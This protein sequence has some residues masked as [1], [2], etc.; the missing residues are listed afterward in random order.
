MAKVVRR[1]MPNLPE[2][3]PDE[4]ANARLA[5][6]IMGAARPGFERASDHI[7]DHLP[8]QRPELVRG[9]LRCGHKLMLAAQSKAGKT[10]AMIALAL[11]VANGYER[12]EGDGWDDG[13]GATWLGRPCR[14]GEVC[15][16][17]GE[18]DVAS[19]WH[20]IDLVARAM[21]PD[22]TTSERRSR[23]ERLMVRSLRGDRDIDVSGVLSILDEGYGDDARPALVIIDPIYKLMQ[24]EENSN[25]ETRPFLKGL[26]AIA[27]WGPSVATT[28]HHAKGKAGERQVIDRAAGAG[29]FGRDPDAFVDLTALDI[30]EGTEAWGRLERALPRLDGEGASEWQARLAQSRIYRANYVLREFPDRW[31]HELLFDFPLLVPID[32]FAD[33]PEEGSQQAATLAATEA[34]RS[35][36]DEAWALHDSLLTDAIDRLGAAGVGHPTREAAYAAYAKRCAEEGVEPKPRATMTDATKPSGTGLSWV[37]D[38]SVRGLVRR[39]AKPQVDGGE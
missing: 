18:M 16:F 22:D 37:Y 9:V 32:G 10:W 33:V 19:L 6:G 38:Q 39:S 28:H 34:R 29:A 8:P 1:L 13:D 14:R 5:A 21:F 3:A 26:D 23:G 17:D 12:L 15:L 4:G 35:K 20:R 36:A 31:G 25:S 24:G 30:R 27:A 2:T 11:A 7:G